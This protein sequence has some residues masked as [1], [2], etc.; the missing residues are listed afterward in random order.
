[1]SDVNLSVYGISRSGRDLTAV[2]TT[3]A[4]DNDYYFPNNG[5]VGLYV[6]N[7]TG[8]TV[9]VTTETPNTVDGLAVAD[10]TSTLATAK[11][12]LLGPFPPNIYNDEDGKVHVA[13]DQTVDVTVVRW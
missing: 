13:F 10:K 8:S 7:A 11:E 3:V 6:K 4:I 1:M 9:T 2:K 5:Q 12:A